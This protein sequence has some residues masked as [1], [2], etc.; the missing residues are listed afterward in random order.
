MRWVVAIVQRQIQGALLMIRY[1]IYVKYDQS[2]EASQ[3]LG[4][5]AK[6][7]KPDSAA[8][9][10]LREIMFTFA[11]KVVTYGGI[12]QLLCWPSSAVKK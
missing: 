3:K 4:S 11:L 6:V 10:S 5:R 9:C 12:I 7:P 2:A 8:L 1:Y